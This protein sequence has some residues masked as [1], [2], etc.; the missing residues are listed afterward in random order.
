MP[1]WEDEESTVPPQARTFT[2][3]VRAGNALP[4]ISHTA[5]F[6]LVL[7]GFEDFRDYY[8]QRVGYPLPGPARLPQIA[9]YDR[10]TNRDSDLD[11]KTFYLDCVKNYIYR[12]ARAAG[13][14]E[15]LLEE[16]AEQ[17]DRV[18]VS[19]FANL[20]GY[21]SFD[22]GRADP[23]LV[24]AD[25]PFKTYLTISSSTFLEDALRRAGKDPV[26]KVCRWRGPVEAPAQE[27]WTIPNSYVPSKEQP[28]VYHLCGVDTHPETGEPMPGTLALTEDDHLEM[29]VNLAQDR[30]KDGADRLPALVRGALYED[31]VLLGFTLDSWAF[32]ALYY[33]L[34]RSSGHEKDRRGVCCIQLPP[35]A[36]EVQEKYLQGYLD[37]EARFDIFWGDMH[38]YAKELQSF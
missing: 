10:H 29:L 33:G 7:F 15:D 4:I 25:L 16:A 30:G 3:R 28:L 38:A 6:D 1:I 21:P 35:D 14:D 23:L 36:R 18:G 31:V 27:L 37:R 5:M 24:L 26:T 11:C 17:V 12:E 32:R 9:N 2:Q 34:I 19:A 20:L 22:R 13:M 8:A